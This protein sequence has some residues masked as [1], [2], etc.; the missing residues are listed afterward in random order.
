MYVSKHLPQR[1]LSSALI[2]QY[3]IQGFI[4]GV[5]LICMV[6]AQPDLCN[7]NSCAKHQRVVLFPV[8][9]QQCGCGI[10]GGLVSDRGFYK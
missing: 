3:F 10:V 5:I 7:V 2:S 6:F 9:K 4:S 8:A 1:R